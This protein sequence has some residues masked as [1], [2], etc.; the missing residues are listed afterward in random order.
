MA[1]G[2]QHAAHS[3]AGR[4]GSAELS[5]DERLG[6]YAARV[7]LG[8]GTLSLFLVVTDRARREELPLEPASLLVANGGQ[9]RGLGRPAVQAILARHGISETLAREG[10]RTTMSSV[11]TMPAYVTFLNGLDAEGLA[12]LDAIEAFWIAR[13]RRLLAARRDA[14]SLPRAMPRRHRSRLR[15]TLDPNRSLRSVF[16]ELLVQVQ[17][18]DSDRKGAYSNK[19]L[20]HLVA[21]TL[22]LV[23][24]SRAQESAS[25]MPALPLRPGGVTSHVARRKCQTEVH[26]ATFPDDAV[27]A[28]CRES[29]DRGRGPILI[30]LPRW[31]SFAEHL[32]EEADIGDSLDVF[33]IEHFL[34]TNLHMRSRFRAENRTL[35]LRSLISRYNEI[36]GNVESD[37]SLRI[38]FRRAV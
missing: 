37:P 12:D 30:T 21:A 36:V 38:R 1:G 7:R 28:A 20:T 34:A 19:V 10:G 13:V 26:V 2:K 22:D 8:K 29:L 4:G 6:E 15:L 23:L 33:D 17:D 11:G 14:A 31:M 5:L 9:V 24:P 18:R 16:R 27:I 3:G 25:S 32:V 35:A